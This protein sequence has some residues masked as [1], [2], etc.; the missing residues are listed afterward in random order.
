MNIVRDVLRR[1]TPINIKMNTDLILSTFFSL[2]I[3]VVF[4][5]S[6]KATTKKK[7]NVTKVKWLLTPFLKKSFKFRKHRYPLKIATY[8]DTK[9]FAFKCETIIL[10]TLQ[11]LEE[12]AKSEIK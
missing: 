5:K 11:N 1:R 6:A 8:S 7:K 3:A 12:K 9:V 10:Y 2:N 4:E